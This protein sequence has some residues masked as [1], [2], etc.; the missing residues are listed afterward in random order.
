M[1]D[2][3]KEL[4]NGVKRAKTLNALVALYQPKKYELRPDPSPFRPEFFHGKMCR[5][6]YKSPT[7]DNNK[8]NTVRLSVE[9]VI[10]SCK[11]EPTKKAII[12]AFEY[13]IQGNNFNIGPFSDAGTY[14]R[15]ESGAPGFISNYEDLE[16]YV[17][18]NIKK[19]PSQ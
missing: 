19:T 15:D 4:N 11:K 6:V 3:L 1:S 13:T 18:E 14:V 9:G 17:I 8:F 16:I 5:I 7:I 2:T 12:P 10:E